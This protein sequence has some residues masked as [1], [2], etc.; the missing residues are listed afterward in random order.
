MGGLNPAHAHFTARRVLVVDHS[1]LREPSRSLL[2]VAR[3]Q[4]GATSRMRETNRHTPE[5]ARWDMVS[6]IDPTE[7]RGGSPK[8]SAGLS[9]TPE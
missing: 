9:A 3:L 7:T 2:L 6:T 5:G 8:H 4:L 1:I